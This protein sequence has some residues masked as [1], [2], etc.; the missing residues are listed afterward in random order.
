MKHE[1]LAELMLVIGCVLL[2]LAIISGWFALL[3]G[4]VL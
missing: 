4:I 2:A 1:T 3:P